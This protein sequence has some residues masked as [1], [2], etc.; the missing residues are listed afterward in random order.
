MR[1]PSVA[2][3]AA[4]GPVDGV[5]GSDGYF[6][7]GVEND[8]TTTGTNHTLESLP[9][10]ISSV[11]L[12][13]PWGQDPD[14]GFQNRND[15]TQPYGSPANMNP[16]YQFDVSFDGNNG[17][18]NA[19]FTFTLK[20]DANFVLMCI[21]DPRNTA[22]ASA[23]VTV[24]GPGASLTQLNTGN[25]KADYVF[26]KISGSKND[27]FTVSEINNSSIGYSCSGGI[28]FEP[29]PSPEPGTL[30]LLAT[31]L[32]GLLAYAWRRWRR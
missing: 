19:A 5:Y 16:A 9:A 15:P 23:G 17:E 6:V 1:D 18:T 25:G 30:V 14:A 10:Y 2:K 11:S 7:A 8:G 4:F 13:Q 32:I 3:V 12:V 24:S 27:V 21:E 29:V 20:N 28:A 22:W 31:G 26:F